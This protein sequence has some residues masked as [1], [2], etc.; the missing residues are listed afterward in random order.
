MTLVV[1]IMTLQ[2]QMNIKIL[3]P[4]WTMEWGYL[5]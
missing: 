4:K 1:T 5:T 2:C 3:R